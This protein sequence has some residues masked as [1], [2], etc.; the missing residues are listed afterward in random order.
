MND[1][2]RLPKLWKSV[3]EQDRAPI[4]LCDLH[5]T[6]VYMNR[7]AIQCYADQGGERLLGTSLLGCH[8]PA[9]CRRIEQVLLWFAES[10]AN[11][12]LFTSRN[13]GENKDV[14]MVALR[15]DDGTLIGYYEKHEFRNAETAGRYDMPSVK[16]GG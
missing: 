4:V 13:D 11:N 15:D 2:N 14:Y 7:A 12:I 5:H 6:V 1:K 16:Q 10:P 8:N 9:S 3:L